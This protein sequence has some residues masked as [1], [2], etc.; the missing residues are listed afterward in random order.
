MNRLTKAKQA[1]EDANAKGLCQELENVSGFSG[2]KLVGT[3]QYL[4]QNLLVDNECYLEI[5]VFQGM[6]LLS[7]A[8]ANPGLSCY[9]IDNFSQFDPDGG[10][11]RLITKRANSN[12][13]NNYNLIESD[14]EDAIDSLSKTL[15]GKK[16]G[17]YFVDGPHDYRSQLICLEFMKP[18]LSENALIVVDDSNYRHV[19]LA[20]SDFIK[21]NP[22]YTLLYESYTNCHPKNAKTDMS[23]YKDGWWNGVN[24]IVRDVENNLDKICP[25]TE[26]DRTLYFNEHIVESA[27]YS[28]LAPYAMNIVRGLLDFNILDL[29]K[30][31][32]MCVKNKNSNKVHKGKYTSMNVFS[33]KLPR[34]RFNSGCQ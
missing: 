19:R 11:K 3:L 17:L 12:G 5:G 31:V 4:G 28:Y 21:S 33:E 13:I 2:K 32:F 8:K 9:G 20:N 7:V 15:Q 25:T 18:Y 10:N 22:E 27:K 1:I 23:D 30:G 29:M 26:R 16:V 24:I 6:T 14:F 34:H